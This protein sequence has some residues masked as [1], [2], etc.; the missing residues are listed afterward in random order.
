MEITPTEYGTIHFVSDGNGGGVIHQ[1]KTSQLM[2]LSVTLS[3]TILTMPNYSL[4]RT[5]V[6]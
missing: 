5:K 3:N 2:D 4:R 6:A 1:K